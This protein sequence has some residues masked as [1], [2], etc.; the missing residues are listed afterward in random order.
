MQQPPQMMSAGPSPTA[1]STEQIQKLLDDNKKLI[2][3]ILEQQNL[4]KVTECAQYQ[5]VL[6]K[7][8]MYLAA[9]ADAQP[10]A[11]TMPS[12]AMPSQT[13]PS[14]M[15]PYA[16]TQQGNHMQHHPQAALSQSQQQQHQQQQQQQQQPSV[17]APKFPFQ[18]NEQQQQHLHQQQSF[19]GHMGM[20][21]SVN[22]GMLQAMQGGVV[23]GGFSRQD[24]SEGA[25][26][27]GKSTS[28]HHGGGD[29]DS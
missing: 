23:G 8:L 20:R 24:G 3:A 13:M 17:F 26:G 18:F 12:Q 4:G 27:E 5:A 25:S 21:P 6:Q 7:N 29:R 15:P 28:G 9:I 11:P 2:M 19:Q 22:N 10:P 1:I 14:Q 16:G